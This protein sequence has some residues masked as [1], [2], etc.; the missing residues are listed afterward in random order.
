M[1]DSTAG[2]F[3]NDEVTVHENSIIYGAPISRDVNELKARI[4]EAAGIIDTAMLGRVWQE[5][6]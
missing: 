1:T 5:F 6:G 3:L 4:M 2:L